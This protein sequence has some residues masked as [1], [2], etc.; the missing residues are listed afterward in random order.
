MTPPGEGRDARGGASAGSAPGSQQKQPRVCSPAASP[1]AGRSSSLPVARDRGGGGLILEYG[2]Q[3]GP[4]GSAW[5]RPHAPCPQSL[6]PWKRLCKSAPHYLS[7]GL[8]LQ[9][10]PGNPTTTY[11]HWIEDVG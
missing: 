5:V 11:N 10:V 2:D 8:P 3:A 6:D 4:K 1:A 9:R 7:K